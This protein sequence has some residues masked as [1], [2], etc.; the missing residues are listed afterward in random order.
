ML[1][2]II[3]TL[4]DGT[5]L[6]NK[7][8]SDLVRER[9]LLFNLSRSLLETVQKASFIPGSPGS[10]PPAGASPDTMHDLDARITPSSSLTA[11]LLALLG[12][13]SSEG[14]D[15]T[16]LARLDSEI[17]D[18]ILGIGENVSSGD[19]RHHGRSAFANKKTEGATHRNLFERTTAL[20]PATLDPTHTVLSHRRY[21]VC[22]SDL[23]CVLNVN[24]MAR[25]FASLPIPLAMSSQG[26]TIDYLTIIRVGREEKHD[27]ALDDW[28]QVS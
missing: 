28:I 17:N 18:L 13:F 8:A 14:E 9:N 21:S 24:G 1:F 16:N 20:V 2:V 7:T 5:R 19:S 22:I 11:A 3:C 25:H 4:M 27:C 23:K 6:L 15:E 10:P 12:S 26:K